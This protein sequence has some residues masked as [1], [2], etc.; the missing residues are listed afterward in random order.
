MKLGPLTI[1][2]PSWWRYMYRSKQWCGI[3]RNQPG[4]RPGRWG[5]Y[6]LGLE[7]GSRQPGHW[8]GCLLKRLGLWPW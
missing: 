2:E 8:F 5:F 3:F 1:C 7:F 4:V 6:V